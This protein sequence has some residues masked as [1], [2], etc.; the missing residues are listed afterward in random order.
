MDFIAR[1]CR[2]YGRPFMILT[3]ESLKNL[4][5]NMNQVRF[6][7]ILKILHLRSI[8]KQNV[9]KMP[10]ISREK[11]TDSRKSVKIY[12][13]LLCCRYSLHQHLPDLRIKYRCGPGLFIHLTF[14]IALAWRICRRELRCAASTLRDVT[15]LIIFVIPPCTSFIV[16]IRDFFGVR[17]VYFGLIISQTERSV[18]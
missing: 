2:V 18:E 12:H 5:I 11:K 7:D 1:Q 17:D 15:S 9:T 10:W 4:C 14:L 13:R 8:I 3:P 16:F 6:L